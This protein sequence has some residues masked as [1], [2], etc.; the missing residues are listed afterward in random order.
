MYEKPIQDTWRP[1]LLMSLTTCDVSPERQYL[2]ASIVSK[3]IEPYFLI[4][5]LMLFGLD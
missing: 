4:C 1:S 5:Y 2:I 3:Q